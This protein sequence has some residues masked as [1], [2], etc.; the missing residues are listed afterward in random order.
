M[1]DIVV[2]CHRAAG[3]PARF[4]AP[5]QGTGHA[6]SVGA[7][8]LCPVSTQRP[9]ETFWVRPTRGAPAHP[10]GSRAACPYYGLVR[11]LWFRGSAWWMRDT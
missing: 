11:P 2:G 1:D 5:N 8:G 9:P 4:P 7:A 3:S 6:R 10:G